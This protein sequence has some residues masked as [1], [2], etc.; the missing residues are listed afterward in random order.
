MHAESARYP[1]VSGR[2]SNGLGEAWGN[3]PLEIPSYAH[4]WR[5]HASASVAALN[6]KRLL[7]ADITLC[8][9]Q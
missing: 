3:Q 1:S 4:G 8:F 9:K 7:L 5:V 2:A 6:R